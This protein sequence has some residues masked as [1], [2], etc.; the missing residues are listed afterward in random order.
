MH[1]ADVPWI[2]TIAMQVSPSL[3]LAAA[4]LVAR[5]PRYPPMS[6]RKPAPVKA[7]RPRVPRVPARPPRRDDPPRLTRAD[8]AEQQL[9]LRRLSAGYA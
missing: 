6:S 1:D 3:N 2:G 8:R 4:M 5:K 9:R 7:S